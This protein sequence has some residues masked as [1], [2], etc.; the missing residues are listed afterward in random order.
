M[1]G[2]L[3]ERVGTKQSFVIM[4]NQKPD[5]KQ[6]QDEEEGDAPKDLLDSTRQLL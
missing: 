4:G 2:R 5:K 6:R 1:G 3:T